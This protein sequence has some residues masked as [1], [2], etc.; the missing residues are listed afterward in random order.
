MTTPKTH[1]VPTPGTDRHFRRVIVESPFAGDIVRNIAYARS[2]LRD[3]LLRGEAPF[4]SHLIYTQE[5]VLDD[6]TPDERLLGMVAGM[7]WA[8]VGEATVVYGDYGISRGMQYGIEHAEHAGRPVEMRTLPDFV[9][10][11][12]SAPPIRLYGP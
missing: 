11:W 6:D 8:A 4:A 5:G 9:L 10:G 2:A 12:A 3:C 1:P 7:S